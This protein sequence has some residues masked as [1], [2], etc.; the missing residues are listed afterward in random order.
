M[1]SKTDDNL[2]GNSPCRCDDFPGNGEF[3]QH[4]RK[5]L[6]RRAPPMGNGGEFWG[7]FPRRSHAPVITDGA[8][9]SGR[10]RRNFFWAHVQQPTRKRENLFSLRW[11]LPAARCASA[12]RSCYVW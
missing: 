1:L 9:P 12:Q 7:I 8:A 2:L 5:F 11:F 6:L 10:R 4:S 3:A